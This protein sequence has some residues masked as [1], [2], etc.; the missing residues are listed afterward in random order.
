[1]ANMKTN[2]V[3]K[4]N[5]NFYFTDNSIGLNF[6]KRVPLYYEYT[7]MFFQ[8]YNEQTRYASGSHFYEQ[9]MESGKRSPKRYKM[10]N[11]IFQKPEFEVIFKEN[12]NISY[13]LFSIFGLMVMENFLSEAEFDSKVI[14]F[15]DIEYK[16]VQAP[17]I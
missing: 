15:I 11:V 16:K 14:N 6:F 17:R 13:N 3:M 8:V 1:M 5:K 4:N 12:P 9:G 2:A 10:Q 7:G